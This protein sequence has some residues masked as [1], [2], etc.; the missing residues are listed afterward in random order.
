MTCFD[1]RDFLKL[2]G[3]ASL[4]LIGPRVAFAQSA[5][6]AR[7]K[8]V[9]VVI[10]QRGGMDGLNAIVPYTESA[11]Y[12]RRP[13]IAI[14]RPG[15]GTNAAIDL[16]GQFGLHPSMAAL[17]PLYDQGKFAAVHAVGL[18]TPSRSH[19]D[20]QDFMERAWMQQGQV[21]TGWL[22][23][24]LGTLSQTGTTFRAVGVGTA[25]PRSLGGPAPVV[26]VSSIAS[27]GITSNLARKEQAIDALESLFGP[28]S[29]MESAGDAAF[30]AVDQLLAV[31]PSQ[32]PVENSASYP[33]T[34]FGTQMRD[35]AAL[36]KSP[37]GVEVA[38]CDIGG[39][40]HHNN[41]AAELPPL[42]DELSRTLAA[43]YA[44][45][46]EARM[47]SVTVV[48]M[49]EFGRRAY[50]NASQ[51][52]DHGR[53]SAM[54]L[55][56]GGVRGRQVYANWPGLADNQLDNGDLAVTTD[57]RAVLSEVLAKRLRAT[58]LDAVFPSYTGG[59]TSGLFNPRG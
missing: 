31:N 3:L 51:G 2:A 10:Y 12:S 8:D 56:G 20:A 50:Q 29:F 35:L 33:N 27:F 11:Y 7:T 26:G 37:L 32:Y 17:K 21:F 59:A 25:V 19:F 9:L 23:R 1:R 22:N 5:D 39:W 58:A 54:F 45:L 49:T 34:R 14:A 43:F 13:N 57:Y 18:S 6:G 40:D 15:S 38:T 41:E 55:L 44:D 47:A 52:T 42:L 48:T 28:D 24:Y 30:A 53:G 36:I 4:P 16:D 46:G